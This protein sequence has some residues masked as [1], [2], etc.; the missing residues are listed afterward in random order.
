MPLKE[1]PNALDGINLLPVLLEGKKLEPRTL[2]WRMS[3][4]KAV[5][6][7][8]WKLIFR[9]EKD[10]PEL[11]NLFQDIGETNNLAS[12]YPEKVLQLKSKLEVWENDVNE[13]YHEKQLEK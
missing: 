10:S 9:N 3:N 5:R 8:K 2:F 6:S 7:G 4:Q 12:Q 1:S 11:Y 13:E